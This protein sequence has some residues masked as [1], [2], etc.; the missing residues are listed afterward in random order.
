LVQQQF[1][2]LQT[3]YGFKIVDGDQPP[4]DIHVELQRQIEQVLIGL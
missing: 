3:T 2:R 1:K 4:D